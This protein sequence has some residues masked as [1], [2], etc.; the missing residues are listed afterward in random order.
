VHSSHDDE[1]AAQHFPGLVVVRELTPNPAILA[2]LI[3]A[4]AP[5]GN[6]LWADEL[7]TAQ[8]GVALRHLKLPA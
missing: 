4:E 1:F 3:P 5:I 2:L 6:G 8:Q 7:E